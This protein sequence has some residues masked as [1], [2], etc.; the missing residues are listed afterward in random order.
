MS[1]AALER[2]FNL[3]AERAW[4]LACVLLHNPHDASDCVQQAFVAAARKPERIPRDDPWPWFSAVV[5]NESRNLRRKFRPMSV[6]EELTM[7]DPGPGPARAMQRAE[8]AAEL[9]LAL[10]TL[11]DAERDALALT[12]L[13]G[14]THA[15]AAQSLG[16]PVKTLSSHVARGIER[17]RRRLNCKEETLMASLS[18]VPVAAPTGGWE[19]ALATWKSAAFSALGH[20]AVAAAGG[21]IMANKAV[22]A[23]GLVIALGLGFGGGLAVDHLA[24]PGPAPTISDSVGVPTRQ[25]AR[26]DS[27]DYAGSQTAR[28]DELETL[29]S[30]G[31][32]AARETERLRAELTAVANERDDLRGVVERLESE[33]APMRAE[34][35]ER[36]P[37]FTFGQYGGIDGVK[38]ANWKELAAANHV[39]VECIREIREAQRKGER[40][41]DATMIRL[42]RHTEIVRKYEYETINVIKS[43]ARHNGEL[44]HPLSV[45]NLIAGELKMVKLPLT[46]Q[47]QAQIEQL[48]LDFE[49]EFEAAQQRYGS[50]TPRCEK[51]LDEYTLKGKFFDK[52]MDLLDAQQR[53]HVVDPANY[54]LASCDLYCPTLMLIHTSPI[55]SGADA[56]EVVAKLRGTVVEKYKIAE[57]QI[58]TLNPLLE[59]WAAD[60]SG[61]L[62]PVPK[63]EARFYSYDHGAVALRAH[64]KLIKAMRDQVTLTEDARAAMLDAYDVYIPRVVQ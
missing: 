56:A 39:V 40:P 61:T 57:S 1:R 48:G 42:Q 34:Q 33:L 2:C 43:F 63:V 41:A 54:R 49:R 10:H 45:A 32:E 44:T 12:Y 17:L 52:L 30:K 26:N 29:R 50:N 3:C 47:Q 4:R 62:T 58:D 38:N 27:R 14:L 55:I 24:V 7:P 36:W 16:V 22:M 64:V 6:D 13:A 23:A 8:T 53:A 35:A 20:T 28:S 37:T 21:T 11:P 59:S 5:V 60:V 19:A 15:E 46:E 18:A 25:L 51:L 31:Q 9:H